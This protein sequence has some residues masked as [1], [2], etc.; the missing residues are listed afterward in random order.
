MIEGTEK[1]LPSGNALKLIG[2]YQVE[3]FDMCRFF[4]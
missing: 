3:Y 4:K 1:V 2:T